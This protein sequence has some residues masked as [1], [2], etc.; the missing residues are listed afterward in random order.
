MEKFLV[1]DFESDNSQ[2][3]GLD[4]YRSDFRVVSAS[5]MA[6]DEEEYPPQFYQDVESIKNDLEYAAQNGYTF[7]VY[8]AGFDCGVMKHHLKVSNAF[9]AIDVW[10]LFN[11][12]CLTVTDKYAKAG[13]DKRST[14]L[15]SAVKYLFGV[16]DYK[17]EYLDYFVER[18]LAK[19][20]KEAHAMVGS[21]PPELLEKYNNADTYWTWEVY[22]ECVKR[23]AEWKIDWQLDHWAYIFEA[24][25]YSDAFNR[26]MEV[27]RTALEKS[28]RTLTRSIREVD[29]KLRAQPEIIEA[30][31]RIN[32]SEVKLTK[33]LIASWKKQF[34]Y[35]KKYILGEEE[36]NAVIAWKKS[37]LFKPFNFRS[38]KQKKLLF[39]D[40]MGMP[41]EKL[42][43]AGNVE[44]SKK[45]LGAYGETGKLLLGMLLQMK[46]RDECKSLLELSIYDGKLHPSLRSG[47][48]ISGR[49]SSKTE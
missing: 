32:V 47:S 23:L 34:G 38:S 48:T 29:E 11:Y 21:L 41:I 43:K 6:V 35:D 16:D 14:K 30:E 22:K 24:E 3:N 17:A 4:Y 26:G 18:K 31:K 8:N 19:D 39:I 33:P 28:I 27:D 2:G 44:L 5:I 37:L 7:L 15:N 46:E 40:V 45:T 10:R 36:C 12:V 1:V 9:N 49:S 20:H 13:S 42:T 25:L